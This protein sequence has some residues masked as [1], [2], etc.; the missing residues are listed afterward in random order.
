MEDHAASSVMTQPESGDDEL[1]ICAAVPTKRKVPL[2]GARQDHSQKTPTTTKRFRR[3]PVPDLIH[4]PPESLDAH[5]DLTLRVLG[6]EGNAVAEIQVCSRTLARSSKMFDTLLYGPYSESLQKHSTAT[7]PWVVEIGEVDPDVLK[8]VLRFLHTHDPQP[9]KWPS[10][11]QLYEIITMIDYLQCEKS[12]RS[13]AWSAW[14]DRISNET[15][16]S[17]RARCG[18]L[19]YVAIYL[20]L[21]DDVVQMLGKLQRNAN[22]VQNPELRRFKLRRSELRWPEQEQSPFQDHNDPALPLMLEENQELRFDAVLDKFDLAASL[23]KRRDAVWRLEAEAKRKALGVYKS[24][25]APFDPRIRTDEGGHSLV[26]TCKSAQA[27]RA[28]KVVCHDAISGSLWQQ[29]CKHD[30]LSEMFFEPESHRDESLVAC[31]RGLRKISPEGLDKTSRTLHGECNPLNGMMQ[32]IDE[33]EAEFDKQLDAYNKFEFTEEMTE[34]LRD[35]KK[36][37]DF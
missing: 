35:R 37:F 5:G 25:L 30:M 31:L 28:T 17:S 2:S 27:R 26:A 20:G 18:K 24:G 33:L 10:E 1:S 29:L 32:E 34:F 11:D 7:A 3:S 6:Q 8:T 14:R 13:L 15:R 21:E 22:N 19:L 16:R 12:F 36:L 4:I 9:L 23:Q